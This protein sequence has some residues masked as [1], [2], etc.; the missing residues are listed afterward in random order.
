MLEDKTIALN[1]ASGLL[2]V[3]FK[4]QTKSQGYQEL[5]TPQKSTIMMCTTGMAKQNKDQETSVFVPLVL[6]RLATE[7]VRS[8]ISW[9]W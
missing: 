3:F 7:E 2:I 6:V 1:L 8:S 5:Q 9:M 4:L